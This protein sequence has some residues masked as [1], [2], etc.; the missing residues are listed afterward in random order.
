MAIEESD[1]V[2]RRDK[3]RHNG[4]IKAFFDRGRATRNVLDDSFTLTQSLH[5]DM[6]N[7][8]YKL[9]SASVDDSGHFLL[10]KFVKRDDYIP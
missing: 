3:N 7:R 4:G 10:V 1:E 5:D 2:K 9:E 6:I 8:G